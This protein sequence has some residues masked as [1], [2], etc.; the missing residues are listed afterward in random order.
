[1]DDRYFVKCINCGSKIKYGNDIIT[2]NTKAPFCCF[3]CYME[4]NGIGRIILN[5]ELGYPSSMW[6]K[7]NE[8]N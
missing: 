8:N 3:P 2:D 7:Y 4:H 1:M 6:Y 5:D